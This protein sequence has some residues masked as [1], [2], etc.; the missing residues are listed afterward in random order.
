MKEDAK[1]REALGRLGHRR[2]RGRPRR[3]EPV[4]LGRDRVRVLARLPR[5]LLDHAGVGAH[6]R[7]RGLPGQAGPAVRAA[8]RPAD[9][10]D[11]LRRAQQGARPRGLLVAH[12]AGGAQGDGRQ[13]RRA[14]RRRGRP[15][16]RGR[17]ADVAEL[18]ASR[19]GRRAAAAGVLGPGRQGRDLLPELGG[20]RE[21]RPPRGDRRARRRRGAGACRGRR[22]S[23]RRLSF[24]FR[25][26]SGSRASSTGAPGRSRR[27]AGPARSSRAAPASAA[28]PSASSP[29]RR[30]R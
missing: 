10:P 6:G 9:H 27:P 22:C 15:R 3:R 29:S 2:R 8:R 23:R 24:F 21:A 30:R 17:G 12:A 19:A 14:P 7:D 18:R 16:G 4:R 1:R 20:R 13:R 26:P 25:L 11:G 5:G 28:C